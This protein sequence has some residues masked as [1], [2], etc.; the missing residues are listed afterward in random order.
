MYYSEKIKIMPDNINNINSINSAKKQQMIPKSEEKK[1]DSTSLFLVTEGL[2]V[3]K[4]AQKFNMSV[5]ELKELNQGKIHKTKDGYEYV[6]C[7]DG[8]NVGGRE[9]KESEKWNHEKGA[10]LAQKWNKNFEKADD[11]KIIESDKNIKENADIESVKVEQKKDS[12]VSAEE[13]P[14]QAQTKSA[15]LRANSVIP[16]INANL[17]ANRSIAESIDKE[18]M[19]GEV[20]DTIKGLW[21]SDNRR[22]VVQKKIS[23]QGVAISNLLDKINNKNAFESYFKAI[24]GVKYVQKNID[25]YQ[26]NLE[27]Y[28]KMSKAAEEDILKKAEAKEKLNESYAKAY[29]TKINLDI[30][31]DDYV[32]SQESGSALTKTGAVIIPALA[33]GGTSLT[34]QAAISGSAVAFTNIADTA[35]KIKVIPK[36]ELT[37][38]DVKNIAGEVAIDTAA[39]LAFGGIS[40]AVSALGSKGAK[41]L[42][43]L[44]SET[45]SNATS[46]A[47]SKIKEYAASSKN[48]IKKA[49]QKISETLNAPSELAENIAKDF[50][51]NF[52]KDLA[53]EFAETSSKSLSSVVKKNINNGA[54]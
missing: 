4:I 21:N 30:A 31:V 33:T 7:G 19:F 5:E 35:V 1:K 42:T 41:G 10:E 44:G 20:A 17:R 24:F 14:V 3:S 15:Q 54:K 37:S 39:T 43:N 28:S 45:V 48:A 23:E 6:L 16:L 11:K 13:I 53:E 36:K 51:E 29:G 49:G 47:T 50:S 46:S 18:G 27:E 26:K 22:S 2:S 40:K 25:E 12:E 9:I 38:D 8:L 52:G 32:T 34:A